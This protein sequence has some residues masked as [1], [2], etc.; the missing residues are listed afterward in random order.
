VKGDAG[1]PGLQG[2]GQDKNNRENG[3]PR[4]RRSLTPKNLS[5]VLITFE[6]KQIN[7]EF[8]DLPKNRSLFVS[9]L[10]VNKSMLNFLI[11]Q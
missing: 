2:G 9:P 4:R 7:N 6:C 11:C 8:L 10:N 3:G 5:F 1:H